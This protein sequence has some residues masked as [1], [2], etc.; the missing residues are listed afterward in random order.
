MERSWQE[1]DQA[2][3]LKAYLNAA[4]SRKDILFRRPPDYWK[5]IQDVARHA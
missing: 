1:L 2:K 4:L 5:R 3:E